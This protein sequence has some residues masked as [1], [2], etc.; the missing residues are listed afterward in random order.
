MF[1][2]VKTKKRLK[3]TEKLYSVSDFVCYRQTKDA[4]KGPGHGRTKTSAV[5]QTKDSRNPE[6][7]RKQRVSISVKV[8]EVC[9]MFK[10]WCVVLFVLT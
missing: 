8:D 5:Q 1:R 10:T 7:V 3:I 9:C 6:E 2:R 4:Q